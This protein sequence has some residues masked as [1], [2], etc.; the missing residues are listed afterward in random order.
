MPDGISLP[1]E[2]TI[3]KKNGTSRKPEVPT[4]HKDASGKKIIWRS[5]YR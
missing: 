5:A 2:Q 3:E 4:S 1:H